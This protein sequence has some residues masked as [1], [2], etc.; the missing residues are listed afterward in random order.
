MYRDAS[1]SRYRL[2][3]RSSSAGPEVLK[4][5]AERGCADGRG[6]RL[7]RQGRGDQR[8]A[9][10]T[11]TVYARWICK[12]GSLTNKLKMGLALGSLVKAGGSTDRGTSRRNNDVS[13]VKGVTD[14]I[15]TSVQRS[16]ARNAGS[17][18]VR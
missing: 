13:G 7:A 3:T 11:R 12:F 1:P 2:M 14:L 18:R 9:S 5:E 4:D 8:T 6:R 17:S 10:W 16:G 15:L